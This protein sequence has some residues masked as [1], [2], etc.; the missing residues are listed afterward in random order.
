MATKM[1][2]EEI[3]DFRTPNL[4]IANYVS[5]WN[6]YDLL[7]Q[8]LQTAQWSPTHHLI[9]GRYCQRKSCSVHLPYDRLNWHRV[10]HG[11][12][13]S[14]Q[15]VVREAHTAGLLLSATQG[16]KSQKHNLHDMANSVLPFGNNKTQKHPNLT[17]N[18]IKCNEDIC[19]YDMRPI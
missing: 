10:E 2:S 11:K 13:M 18:K 4:K 7:R 17:E 5:N 3:A 1:A 8:S 15:S 12:L 6:V 16:L 19:F 14:A 9:D